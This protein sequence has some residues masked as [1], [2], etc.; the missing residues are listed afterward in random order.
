MA[1]A[2]LGAGWAVGG[3][4]AAGGGGDRGDAKGE[5]MATIVVSASLSGI[6]ES[7]SVAF[8][9]NLVILVAASSC[10]QRSDPKGAKC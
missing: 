4:D 3:W 7:K 1:G 5:P 10:D 8:S 9:L 6:T 2:G